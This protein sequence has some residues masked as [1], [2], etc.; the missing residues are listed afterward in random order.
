MFV[1]TCFNYFFK[2]AI[3]DILAALLLKCPSRGV[4]ASWY[5]IMWPRPPLQYF[6]AGTACQDHAVVICLVL[7]Q[8]LDSCDPVHIHALD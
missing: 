8:F 6:C 7:R 5:V 3:A 1:L 2:S 4:L